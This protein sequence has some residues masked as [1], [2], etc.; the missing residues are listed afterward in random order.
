MDD[1]YAIKKGELTFKEV[2][3]TRDIY[4][5]VPKITLPFYYADIFGGYMVTGS[6]ESEAFRDLNPQESSDLL[7]GLM[8]FHTNGI[9]HLDVRQFNIFL[10]EGTVKLM[11][12]SS[13][14]YTA[15]PAVWVKDIL[16]ASKLISDD[17]KS[18]PNP[19][20]AYLAE[21]VYD[22]GD[23]DTNVKA[24]RFQEGYQQL[25]TELW[26]TTDKTFAES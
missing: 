15:D 8:A 24:R 19:S 7:D 12:F 5:L 4:E 6:V 1:K 16:R 17:W 22:W 23:I 2:F 10:S 18:Y 13:A 9:A 3:I 26:Q 25:L 20:A 21:W 11:N 14:A